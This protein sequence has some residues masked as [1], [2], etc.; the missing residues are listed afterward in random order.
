MGTQINKK[1]T[2]KKKNAKRTKRNKK[3]K[4]KTKKRQMTRAGNLGRAPANVA[5]LARRRAADESVRAHPILEKSAGN[6]KHSDPWWCSHQR[7]HLV[8]DLCATLPLAN[9]T[10]IMHGDNT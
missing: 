7:R 2:Q 10:E 9:K 8:H 3:R 6:R 4:R 5:A 1:A